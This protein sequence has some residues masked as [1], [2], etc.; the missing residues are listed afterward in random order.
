MIVS[1]GRQDETDG[2]KRAHTKFS[3]CTLLELLLKSG[4]REKKR[5]KK[6]KRKTGQDGCQACGVKIPNGKNVKVCAGDYG[7]A[8]GYGLDQRHHSS[9]LDSVQTTKTRKEPRLREVSRV[10]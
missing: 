9:F 3:K 5:E 8:L 10:G 2:P 7:T 1:W 4:E 6:G